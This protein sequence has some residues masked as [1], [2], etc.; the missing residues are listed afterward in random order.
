MASVDSICSHGAFGGAGIAVSGYECLLEQEDREGGVVIVDMKELR[1]SIPA[2]AKYTYVDTAQRGLT[3]VQVT[4]AGSAA[5]QLWEDLGNH[6]EFGALKQQV[7][8]GV[9]ELLHVD[10]TEIAIVGSTGQGLNIL[11][12]AL[13]WQPG[14]NVVVSAAEH[15][16]NFYPWTN[17]RERGVEVR[18]VPCPT[19][20][21][22]PEDYEPYIDQHTRL[23]AASLVTFYPGG[24]LP[25]QEL[26]D[27][28]HRRGALLV[29]DV[30]QAAAM[31]PVYP[32]E[33]GADAVS[34]A[35]YKGLMS[36]YGAGFL[37]IAQPLLS[38]LKPEH[39]YMSGVIGEFGTGGG[40][41]TDPNYGWKPTAGLFEPGGDNLAGLGQMK[42]ALEIIQS[43]GVEQIGI[44]VRSL[45]RQ[46]AEGAS[47]LGY[48]VDTPMDHLANIV[49]L[50]ME[51]GKAIVSF[52]DEKK[53]KAS[54][55]RYGLRMAFHAYNTAEDVDIVLAALAEYPL[56]G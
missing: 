21:L 1:A 28:A 47:R 17:L 55:R 25:A 44:H 34:A 2:L 9:A 32:R 50:H 27:L 11:A 52:L 23:V 36:A 12:G 30:I 16:S 20:A 6:P 35:A 56:R 24:W 40:K 22:R 53:I 49:C 14:D 4:A 5:L 43:I 38:Q 26:A 45:A 46:L 48:Q 42:A 41:M 29:L 31:M 19:G 7:R 15:P 13:P 3:P 10:S 33:L 37:Y 51:D 18:L 54:A 8:V 39:L